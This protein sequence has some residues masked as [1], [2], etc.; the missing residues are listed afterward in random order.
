MKKLSISLGILLLFGSLSWAQK[1][2]S[3]S[4]PQLGDTAPSF[5]AES[6]NGQ[7]N[8]PGDYSHQWKIIF[9]HPADFTPVCSSE[10]IE[11][12]NDQKSFDKIHT[13]I[14]IVS[15]DGVDN[16]REW[17]KSME[18]LKYKDKNTE[19][20]YFPLIED[21]DH[22]IAQ[23]YGMIHPMTNSTKDVRGVFII[24]PNDKI[25]AMFFYPM[26]IGRNVE[27]IKRT[28][29][30]MQIADKDEV[31]TPAN[32]KPGDDVLLPYVKDQSKDLA[33]NNSNV[34]QVTWYMLF[35]RLGK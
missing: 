33:L 23:K 28:L 24:D 19:K 18:S 14:L 35:K 11:L 32:W 17:I 4:I 21:K 31:L 13:K 15:T 12:A 5:T 1:S 16:H 34:Y 9:C 7:I 27:E 8:F 30:A 25:R 10:I 26:N 6:T 2:N 29:L 3:V 22:S 20:I